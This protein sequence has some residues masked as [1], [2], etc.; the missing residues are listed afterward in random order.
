MKRLY[1]LLLMNIAVFSQLVLCSCTFSEKTEWGDFLC[2]VNISAETEFSYGEGIEFVKR[3]ND[4]LLLTRLST[5][6]PENMKIVNLPN[7]KVLKI[8][9]IP[10]L[11][12]FCGFANSGDDVEFRVSNNIFNIFD[13]D[14]LWTRSIKRSMGW[15]SVIYDKNG[16][17]SCIAVLQGIEES[18]SAFLLLLNPRDGKTVKRFIVESDLFLR[19]SR[20]W[21]IAVSKNLNF[22]LLCTSNDGP[23]KLLFFRRNSDGTHFKYMSAMDVSYQSRDEKFLDFIRIDQNIAVISFQRGTRMHITPNRQQII[24]YDLKRNKILFEYNF[25]AYAALY[26]VAISEDHKYV[27]LSFDEGFIRLYQLKNEYSD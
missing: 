27:A 9:R 11:N 26:D 10:P 15:P 25:V 2:Q 8:E 1:S 5:E 17:L 23:E 14:P 24:F 12:I 19:T 20:F 6:L 16:N 21:R 18:R 3:N 7:G 13:I 22:L 4:L